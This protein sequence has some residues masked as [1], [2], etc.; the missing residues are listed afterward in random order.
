M[1]PSTPLRQQ[2]RQ[3]ARDGLRMPIA[4]D[5][6]L[7][8]R[9]DPEAV[10]RDGE[11]LGAVMVETARRY[12]TPLAFSV[13]DLRLEKQDLLALLAIET[14]APDT[15]HFEGAPERALVDRLP[16]A[17]N[18]PSSI[19]MAANERALGV[20]ARESDL[21]P[22]GMCIGPFSLM[23]KLLA[24]PIMAVYQAASGE[25]PEE[26]EEVAALEA[27]LEMG[28]QVILRSIRR[29]V[30]AG[31]RAICLCEPAFNSVYFSPNQFEAAP[32]A[33]ERWFLH[34]HRRIRA[35]FAELGAELILHDCGELIPGM[36]R[37]LD[38]LEP[39]M[40]SLGSPV[41]L[42]EAA[43]LVRPE[44]VLFGNLPTKN[45]YSDAAMSDDEVVRRTRELREK[46]AASGHPFILGSECDV[47]AVRGSV[48]TIR[49]KVRLMLDA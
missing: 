13:M 35:L 30:A 20:V 32:E 23:T 47:L 40:L 1:D 5:L 48:D 41:R 38:A 9:A 39:A 19:R 44:T 10:L 8:D 29:Q 34:Y 25:E 15:F 42:W 17:L 28:T 2:L 31:A 24:D 36:V 21:V 22:V 46:M 7:H 27:V 18:A 49:R 45:F 26:D 11:A 33:V 16:G 14:E 4:V 43:P 12:R 6:V 37:A 3:W